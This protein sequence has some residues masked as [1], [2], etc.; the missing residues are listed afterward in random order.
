MAHLPSSKRESKEKP[1]DA[2][3]Y[4]RLFSLIVFHRLAMHASV[5]HQR[6]RMFTIRN[7]VRT[8]MESSTYRCGLEG[9]GTQ[10]ARFT[11]VGRAILIFREMSIPDKPATLQI[12]L[13][14][15]VPLILGRYR[16]PPHKNASAFYGRGGSYSFDLVMGTAGFHIDVSRCA[17][18]R[19]CFHLASYNSWEVR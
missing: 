4:A 8:F 16:L 10:L 5:R 6:V 2:A 1:E 15:I 17:G 19:L 12:A 14:T 7:L 18:K 3:D 9:D 13:S 11:R